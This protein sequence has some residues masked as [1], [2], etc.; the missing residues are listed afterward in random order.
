MEISGKIGGK[1]IEQVDLQLRGFLR[2][3]PT[4]DLDAERMEYLRRTRG[5][6]E[7]LQSDGLVELGERQIRGPGGAAL[8]VVTWQPR[9]PRQRPAGG[10]PALLHIHG[11][12]YVMGRPQDQDRMNRRI[13][14]ELG[15]LVVSVDYRLAPEHPFPAALDDCHA[16]LAWL[17]ASADALGVDR[18]R[19][20]L[21][22]ES[23]GGGLAACLSA[24]ARDAGEHAVAFQWLV[25]PM[26]DDRPGPAPAPHRAVGRHVWTR[27]SNAFGWRSYLGPQAGASVLPR[28][29]AAAREQ[30]LRGLPPTWL[31]VGA[32]DLFLDENL[33]YVRGLAHAGV[34][35]A[36]QVYAGAYH[37]FHRAGDSAVNRAF[38]RDG[39][40]ALQAW[41]DR[42]PA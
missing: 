2:E 17:H 26:L 14:A 15:C 13:A 19:I 18:R 24:R 7:P 6:A 39:L 35:V 21:K 28:Y 12:G 29:A 38:E 4:Q 33:A 27:A 41:F 11:G 25:A 1:I 3:Y 9:A 22:A 37:S 42:P 8:R 34:P 30:D 5:A 32:L 20:G 40:A 31:A 16:A 10:G 36:L 23:A